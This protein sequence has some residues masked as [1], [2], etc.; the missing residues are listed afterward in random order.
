MSDELRK[1]ALEELERAISEYEDELEA[2]RNENRALQSS[3]LPPMSIMSQDILDSGG[4]WRFVK[5]DDGTLG[6]LWD[7]SIGNVLEEHGWVRKDEYDEL[8]ELVRYAY[9][10]AIHSDHATCDDCRRMNSRCILADRM[11]ELGIE[12]S[13][14]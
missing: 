3:L 7:D 13:D 8:H 14:G 5:Q 12:V 2:L 1:R 11:Q 10:C 9:E 4:F 6:L